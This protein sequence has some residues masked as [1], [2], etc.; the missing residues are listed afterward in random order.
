ME[1]VVRFLFGLLD[2]QGKCTRGLLGSGLDRVNIQFRIVAH[3]AGRFDLYFLLSEWC[4]LD[5]SGRMPDFIW[6]GAQ[7]KKFKIGN[8]TFLDSFLFITSPLDGFPKAFGF[9]AQKGFFP[10]DLN[11]EAH[12]QLNEGQGYKG[13][14]PALDNYRSLM[15]DDKKQKN[16]EKWHGEESA[17]IDRELS[18]GGQGWVFVEKLVKYCRQD[19]VVL[20]QGFYDKFKPELTELTDGIIPGLQN[21]TIAGVANAAWRRHLVPYTV[22]VTQEQGYPP[23]TQSN[24]ARQYLAY[25]NATRYG[26][27]LQTAY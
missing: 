15:R 8:L 19:V 3:N 10:H 16:I 4:H 18:E 13:R 23:D 1:G 7:I 5:E 21:C 24:I 20:R 9:A 6:N 14:L 11:I 25:V 2:E 27:L 17:R 22:G 26:G 12:W